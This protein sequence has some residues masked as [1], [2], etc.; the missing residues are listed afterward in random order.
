MSAFAGSSILVELE[1]EDAGF[2]GGR[3]TGEPG[4]KPSEEGKNNKLNP[5]MA[6]GRNRTRATLEKGERS[7]HCAIPAICSPP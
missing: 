4:E 2:C 1:F 7:H 6:P 5:H 3:K